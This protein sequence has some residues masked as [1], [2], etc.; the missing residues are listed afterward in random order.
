MVA[1][2]LLG[3]DVLFDEPLRSAYY[4]AA[5]FADSGRKGWTLQ[6]AREKGCQSSLPQST[7]DTAHCQW[8]LLLSREEVNGFS[9]ITS[10]QFYVVRV[11]LVCY[12][13]LEF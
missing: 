7:S 2:S 12:V 5:G 13:F 4:H 6:T 8:P 1:N 10:C 9:S 3:R 11:D